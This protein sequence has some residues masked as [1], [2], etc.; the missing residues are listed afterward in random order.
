MKDIRT[1]PE[2]IKPLKSNREYDTEPSRQ[3]WATDLFPGSFPI[4]FGVQGIREVDGQWLATTT[5]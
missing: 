4:I 1:G 3:G 5:Y 2:F